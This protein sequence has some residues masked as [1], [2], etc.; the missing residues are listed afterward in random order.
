MKKKYFII[1]A[2]C[3]FLGG[4]IIWDN[5]R[6]CV[7][8]YRICDSSLPDKFEGYK[9]VQVSD[10][11]NASFG[12]NQSYLIKKIKKE[13]PDIIAITGDLIDS[14]HTNIDV[15][16][17]FVDEAVKI[18]PVYYVTGNHEA[19]LDNYESVL[20]APLEKL[21]VTVLDNRTVSIEKNEQSITLLGV[22]DPDFVLKGEWGV[23][24]N[25][26]VDKQLSKLAPKGFS[27]LLSH[28]PELISVYSDYSISC[29]L[30]GHAHGGQFRIPFIGGVV[31]PDQGFF[32]KYTSGIYKE[33]KTQ[34]VV[35]RGLG[36]SIIPIRI[37]NS[38]EV[39][40]VEL[41]KGR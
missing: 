19:W 21:G 37:N 17:K 11:H 29:A 22:D 34:M 10:L 15:A 2:I 9:I 13:T 25:V 20:K 28:R 16:M 12:T 24:S 3:I 39:V 4:W 36:E 14:N 26:A 5:N 27:V 35:S 31:A 23:K 38:P 33:G 41:S 8:N 30:C 40:V 32:P 7:S 18:A 1:I 6:I